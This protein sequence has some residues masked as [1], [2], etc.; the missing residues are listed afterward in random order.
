M[1]KST[2]WLIVIQF[3]SW[4][5]NSFSQSDWAV[6]IVSPFPHTTMNSWGK[7]FN[8][9]KVCIGSNK[10]SLIKEKWKR[11]ICEYLLKLIIKLITRRIEEWV[12]RIEWR[13]CSLE[14]LS[15]ILQ[16]SNNFMK[17]YTIPSNVV[18]LIILK[19]HIHEFFFH[20]FN[21][22]KSS[23]FLFSYHKITCSITLP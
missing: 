1:K 13:K 16:I 22:T 9:M 12:G 23:L 3:W 11:V 8:E 10:V 2:F 4:L 7:V 15:M 19:T 14:E 18:L 17:L 21:N 5:W 20:Y 6:V